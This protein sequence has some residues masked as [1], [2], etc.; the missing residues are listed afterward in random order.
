MNKT[1]TTISAFDVKY[2]PVKQTAYGLLYRTWD[3]NG[4]VMYV[5]IPE[6]AR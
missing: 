6:N 1:F 5:S 4:N 2:P 3:S